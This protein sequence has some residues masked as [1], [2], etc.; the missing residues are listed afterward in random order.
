MVIQLHIPVPEQCPPDDQPHEHATDD[1]RSLEPQNVCADQEEQAAH[2]QP[3]G[4]PHR[5]SF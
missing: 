3:T 5:T 4:V 1:S 2:N